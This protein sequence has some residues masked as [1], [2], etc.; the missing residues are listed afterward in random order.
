M[1]DQTI[2]SDFVVDRKYCIWAVESLPK[3]LLTNKV[4]PYIDKSDVFLHNNIIVININTGRDTN[5]NSLNK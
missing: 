2:I 4:R 5:S 3:R 1:Y